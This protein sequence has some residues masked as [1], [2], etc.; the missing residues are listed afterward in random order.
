MLIN[1]NIENSLAR[2]I[3][4]AKNIELIKRDTVLLE[5]VTEVA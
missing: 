3:D 4:Y 5:M 2:Y 1:M